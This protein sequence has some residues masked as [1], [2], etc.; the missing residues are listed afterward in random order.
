MVI[1]FPAYVIR[2]MLFIKPTCL[3]FR[4]KIMR[5]GQYCPPP[6]SSHIRAGGLFLDRYFGTS[7][8]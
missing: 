3:F 4:Q 5:N 8:N 6:P 7:G 1:S 2:T